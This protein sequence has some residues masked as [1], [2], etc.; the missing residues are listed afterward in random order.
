MNSRKKADI[1]K[2]PIYKI[3]I[4][5][6]ALTSVICAGYYLVSGSVAA[7]SSLLG[8][9]IFVIPQLYFGVK[10]FLYSGARSIQ[11]IVINFYKGESTKLVIIALSFGLIFKF[12]E[13]L[14]YLALYSTFIS[15]LVMNCF[16]ALLVSKPNSH[17]A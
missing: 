16:S 13:P 9:V 1:N 3:F 15:V 14:D 17:K 10:A 12:V 2:P 7:Y 11:K 5:Q 8:G 4:A 6:M